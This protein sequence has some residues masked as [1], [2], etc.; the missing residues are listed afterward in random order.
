LKE[1]LFVCIGNTC[2]SPMA[3]GFAKHYGSDVMRASSAGLSPVETVIPETVMIMN[4]VGIDISGHV[5]MWYQ[6]LAVAR[7]DIVVNMS[8]Y[9]LPG[10]PPKELIEWKVNDPYQQSPAVYRK[11]RALIEQNVMQLVL[12]L[13]REQRG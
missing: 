4:E 12:R 9:R 1:V 11:V 7:Y 10:K 6:P 2:R 8:G 13:R 5:P 3:E